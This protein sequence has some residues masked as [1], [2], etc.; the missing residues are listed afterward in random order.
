MSDLWKLVLASA[1]HILICGNF[2]PSVVEPGGSHLEP[3]EHWA[4]V[5][6]AKGVGTDVDRGQAS[7]VPPCFPE[8]CQLQPVPFP[9]TGHPNLRPGHHALGDHRRRAKNLTVLIIRS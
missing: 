3:L 4:G 7:C 1:A 2:L 5:A 8:G 6:E 9:D